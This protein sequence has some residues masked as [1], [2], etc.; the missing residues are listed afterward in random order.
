MEDAGG[1]SP[2]AVLSDALGP[3]VCGAA[4]SNAGSNVSEQ[5][6][7]GDRRPPDDSL[8]SGDDG[9]GFTK[10]CQQS[11]CRQAMGHMIREMHA[12]LQADLAGADA[13]AIR[14]LGEMV[15]L[16]NSPAS[17]G[18]V[19]GMM[20]ILGSDGI[21]ASFVSGV[22]LTGVQLGYGGHGR[23][24][25]DAPDGSFQRAQERIANL[26]SLADPPSTRSASAAAAG[27]DVYIQPSIPLYQAAVAYERVGALDTYWNRTIE[28]NESWVA[29]D[30]AMFAGVTVRPSAAV[31]TTPDGHVAITVSAFM[32][33][34]ATNT[35][36]GMPSDAVLLPSV[37]SIN[38]ANRGRTANASLRLMS[39]ITVSFT[40]VSRASTGLQPR[41]VYFDNSLGGGWKSDGCTTQVTASAVECSCNHLTDFSVLFTSSDSSR[42][43]NT[44]SPEAIEGLEAI[45]AVG[46]ALGLLGCLV[47]L[48]TFA[49]HP[50]LVN[51]PQK[52]IASLLATIGA[53]F[54]VFLAGVEPETHTSPGSCKF[55]AVLLHYLILSSW[56]WMLCE[57]MHMYGRFVA[58][59]GTDRPFWQYATFGWLL[60]LSVIAMSAGAF[61][62]DYGP[63]EGIDA[64][65]IRP[66][67]GAMYLLL[68]PLVLLLCFSIAIFVRVVP[69]V[70]GHRD[71][72]QPLKLR[73]RAFITFASALGFTYIFAFLVFYDGSIVWRFLFV[74]ASTT[75]AAVIWYY[76]VW[77]RPDFRRRI[78]QSSVFSPKTI[79]KTQTQTRSSVGLGDTWRRDVMA[80]ASALSMQKSDADLEAEAGV[81]A[82]KLAALWPKLA[83]AGDL[84]AM[85][86]AATEVFIPGVAVSDVEYLMSGI[87]FPQP[88]HFF[89]L[90]CGEAD[91]ADSFDST[92]NTFVEASRQDAAAA[93]AAA[94]AAFL[95]DL[96]EDSQ[97]FEA[98]KASRLA[99]EAEGYLVL[100]ADDA[101]KND[102]EGEG[103]VTDALARKPA[104]PPTKDWGHVYR[105]TFEKGDS[106]ALGLDINS[107]NAGVPTGTYVTGAAY[108][109]PAHCGLEAAGLS[110]DDGLRIKQINGVHLFHDRKAAVYSQVMASSSL[111]VE[112]VKDPKG[113][114]VIQSSTVLDFGFGTI[115][116]AAAVAREVGAIE[117][118][119]D[120]DP[121]SDEDD[122]IAFPDAVFDRSSSPGAD[123]DEGMDS[124]GGGGGLSGGEKLLRLAQ[125]A[126]FET[127]ASA[128]A[129]RAHRVRVAD[130]ESLAAPGTELGELEV[131]G[132]KL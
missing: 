123:S 4:I 88:V 117:D 120:S 114:T 38:V 15:D 21:L 36:Y 44:P 74:L 56:A 128:P 125:V 42:S 61:G 101:D 25:A 105:A 23:Y 58:V 59:F 111:E 71:S 27:A 75:Q 22:A 110:V 93:D 39:P 109:L 89:V 81:T 83:D 132:F 31:P 70:L 33:C 112:F 5:C 60:P 77:R 55:V 94:A 124:L 78:R 82:N 43:T 24:E 91:G 32:S 73:A 127:P 47:T 18:A 98:W 6:G 34:P 68:C 84:C 54:V 119:V 12:L 121:P 100:A 115:A 9:R 30:S 40:N 113:F 8:G 64:C 53:L 3:G 13:S 50:D 72:S 63:S 69:A 57:G 37:V 80:Q 14:A 11:C 10:P 46:M 28:L 62:D 66:G 131:F 87:T 96:D 92:M 51:M 108:G 2:C 90:M 76:H 29:L 95:Q 45:S 41:C 1:G 49:V 67:T 102:D 106:G 52:I 116:A 20:P 130:H 118:D 107:L 65:W 79:S 126:Q 103:G 85:V 104:P 122:V 7:N 97:D 17:R 86:A 26:V 35:V 129:A 19:L 99:A 16:Y 48:I